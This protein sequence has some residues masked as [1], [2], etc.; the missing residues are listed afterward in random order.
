[1][2]LILAAVAALAGG[3]FLVQTYRKRLTPRESPRD[4]LWLGGVLVLG[5]VALVI[6]NSD[7]G[8]FNRLE[9]ALFVIALALI[10]AGSVL[11]GLEKGRL[12]L[13]T[14]RAVYGVLG[15]VLLFMLTALMPVLAVRGTL[16]G[17]L[18]EQATV[19]PGPTLTSQEIAENVYRDVIQVI[20]DET[21]YTPQTVS[22]RL[23]SGSASVADMVR[24]TGGDLDTV[25]QAITVILSE[26]VRYLLA[27]GRL[28]ETEASIA[29]SGMETIVSVGVE[30]GLTN[31]LDRFE[32]DVTF[33]E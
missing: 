33:D 22:D 24:E 28:G 29:L 3:I 23:D 11:A 19:T 20:A 7:G 25:V 6:E 27:E 15:G 30:T 14:S 17:L 31:L 26:Q 9:Y 32:S 8:S 12:S 18:A 4:L 2:T 10:M 5:L 16:P 13:K 21:G 1:M